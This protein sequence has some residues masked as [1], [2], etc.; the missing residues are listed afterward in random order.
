[1]TP[2]LALSRLNNFYLVN[3]CAQGFIVVAVEHAD[4]RPACNHPGM[5]A[6]VAFKVLAL[7]WLKAKQVEK[8]Y[9]CLCSMPIL[10][11]I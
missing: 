11:D 10:A 3:V 5:H 2:A 7:P 8:L 9:F 6:R 1:M 4:G